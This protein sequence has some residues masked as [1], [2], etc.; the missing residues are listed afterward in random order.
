[1]TVSGRTLPQT[2]SPPPPPP[3]PPAAGYPGSPGLAVQ[4]F[5]KMYA[6][7]P[8]PATAPV[9]GAAIA[10]TINYARANSLLDGYNAPL[11][12]MAGLLWNFSLRFTGAHAHLSQC[13]PV[14]KLADAQHD[15]PDAQVP[16]IDS[17]IRC[18]G[19]IAHASSGRMPWTKAVST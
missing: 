6:T 17:P 9:S 11:F 14:S 2:P 18:W 7:L 15:C 19:Q 16:T 12:A 10:L 4:I 3:P 1:M 5:P 13:P 8:V